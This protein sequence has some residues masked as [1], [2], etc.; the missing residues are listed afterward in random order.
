M[1]LGVDYINTD[2][3]ADVAKFMSTLPTAK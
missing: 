1:K 2:H 3:I